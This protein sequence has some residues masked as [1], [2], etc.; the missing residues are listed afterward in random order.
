MQLP[1]TEN[2]PP[3][4][5]RARIACADGTDRFFWPQG[6]IEP[7]EWP[8]LKKGDRVEFEPIQHAKGARAVNV[9]VL[10]GTP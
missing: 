10:N 8:M 9:R 6:L 4:C 5:S 3:L 1:A 7:F 2:A